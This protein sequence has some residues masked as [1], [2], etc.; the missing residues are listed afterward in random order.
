MAWVQGQLLDRCAEGLLGQPK[1]LA[2]LREKFR[3]LVK[4][5]EAAK[6]AHGDLQHGNIL[7][8]GKEL[9]LIDYDGMW[10]RR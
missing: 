10:F 6:F 1:E 9:L 3:T 7:V 5:V 2:G 8:S 4:E